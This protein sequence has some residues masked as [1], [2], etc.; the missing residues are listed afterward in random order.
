MNIKIA[1]KIVFGCMLVGMTCFLNATEVIDMPPL[2]KSFIKIMKKATNEYAFTTN[3]LKKQKINFDL[4][5]SVFNLLKDGS[6]KDWVGIISFINTDNS[7][8]SAGLSIIPLGEENS[9]SPIT[10]GTAKNREAEK[11]FGINMRISIGT[12]LYDVLS[13][14]EVGD[15]VVFSGHF[16]PPGVGILEITQDLPGSEPGMA[17]FTA[18]R[19]M[20]LFK[21]T[22]IKKIQS[23][24][25]SK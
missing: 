20:G 4:P 6:A 5:K 12:H 2:E 19:G 16:I 7:D 1:K 18:P 3:E 15:K 9:F 8:G 10:L 13:E 17:T 22:D 23:V 24:K 14:L 21:F 11:K 25:K